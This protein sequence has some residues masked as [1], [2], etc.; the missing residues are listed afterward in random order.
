MLEKTGLFL[1]TLRIS[2]GTCNVVCLRYVLLPF[3]DL[4]SSTYVE[5]G[6]QYCNCVQKLLQRGNVYQISEKIKRFCFENHAEKL[7]YF[8]YTVC[9]RPAFG[10]QRDLKTDSKYE[11]RIETMYIHEGSRDNVQNKDIIL[12]TFDDAAC[13]TRS[14][15]GR[16]GSRRF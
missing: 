2:L 13:K 16:K 10:M 11:L 6:T 8:A 14:L 9:D 4:W 12:L 1:S 15:V 5:N 7:I 3:G